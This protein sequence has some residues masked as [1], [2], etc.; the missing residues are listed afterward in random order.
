VLPRWTGWLIAL[1]QPLTMATG[2]ALSPWAAL[3]PHGSYSGAVAHGLV[4]LA[5]ATALMRLARR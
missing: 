4:C 2:L 3:E 1:T 5:L